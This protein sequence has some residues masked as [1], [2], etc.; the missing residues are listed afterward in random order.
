MN[1]FSRCSLRCALWGAVGAL[2]A[3]SLFGFYQHGWHLVSVLLMMASV[4]TALTGLQAIRRDERVFDQV[5]AL[6]RAVQEGDADFRITDIDS[7]HPLAESLWNINEGRDQI[8]AFFREID[9]TFHYIEQD[10]YFRYALSAGL[11]GQYRKTMERINASIEAMEQ[12]AYRR[13]EDVFLARLGELKTSNLLENLQRSQADLARI[14]EQMRS[15]AGNT[16]ASVEVAMRGQGTIG[17]VIDNLRHLVNKMSGVHDTSVQ[18]GSHSQ[19]VG[20]ILEMITGIADQTNLLALNAAIEAA[21][22]GEHGRGFAVVA[23]EVKKLAQRTK[24]AT[25]NVNEVI[26]GFN[27]S[28]LADDRRGQGDVGNGG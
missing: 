28:A 10:C 14:T 19:E 11:R 7:S 1:L 6:G 15:V 20:E 13:Q 4:A 17:Q 3:A 24:E 26:G 16:S 12:T 18:L 8:E 23:D 22:A 27:V 2:F 21:R 25:A 9:A 5:R